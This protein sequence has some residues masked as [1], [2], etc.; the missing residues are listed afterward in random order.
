MSFPGILGIDGKTTDLREWIAA[1]D[2]L[3]T[4]EKM[5]SSPRFPLPTWPKI[6]IF[7]TAKVSV[8]LG[9]SMGLTVKL[10]S[11]RAE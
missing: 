1:S 6:P 7:L 8:I 11:V 9:L 5:A 10:A 3:D 4:T 2:I